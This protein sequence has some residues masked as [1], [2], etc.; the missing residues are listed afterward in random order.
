MM[1]L[2]TVMIA[3]TA[4]PA[5]AQGEAGDLLGRVN[6]LRASVGRS[7]YSLNGALAAAAQSQAQW[8]IDTGSVSHTRP[9]GSGPRTRA[10]NAGYPSQ[11]VTE[12]IYGGTNATANDA[13]TF[14][15]NSGVHYNSL[16]NSNYSEIGIGIARGSWGAA[17]VLVFGNPTGSY[18]AP[19]AAPPG[20]SSGASGGNAGGGSSAPPD[21]VL[22]LDANGNIMHAVQPGDTLGDI[23]LIYGYGWDDLPMLMELNGM[24]DVRDLVVGTVFLVPSQMGTFTPTV[25]PNT[26]VPTH[27]PTPLPPTIT[28]FVAVIAPTS[29]PGIPTPVPTLDPTYEMVAAV[30][31]TIVVVATASQPP[32]ETPPATAAP[33]ATAAPA[34]SASTGGAAPGNALPTW[35]LIALGVQG[36]VIVGAGVEFA[37]RAISGRSRAASGRQA[38][39]DRRRH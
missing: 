34:V 39:M 3:L 14:W 10:A 32:I 35:A 5:S 26:P 24:N 20:G 21:F 1:C 33:S 13:W 29:Q 27:T 8:I 18:N 37:R 28:P 17:F 19:G 31:A 22:G 36:L 6:A 9:D 2:I 12:N 7:A 11:Q 38:S 25:D 16:V 23:A 15:V 30:P 4:A